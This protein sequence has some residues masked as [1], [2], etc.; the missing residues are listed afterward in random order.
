MDHHKQPLTRHL[1]TNTLCGQDSPTYPTSGSKYLRCNVE[2]D[3]S[4]YLMTSN[5]IGQ[6]SPVRININNDN[7]ISIN[8]LSFNSYGYP[9]KTFSLIYC[10]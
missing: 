2:Q 6:S 8:L 5:N 3:P 1:L 9:T 7:S 10:N 4:V